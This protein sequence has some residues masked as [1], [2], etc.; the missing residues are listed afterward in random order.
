ME[1]ERKQKANE[2]IVE[3]L[4]N[5][6]IKKYCIQIEIDVCIVLFSESFLSFLMLHDSKLINIIN[7]NILGSDYTWGEEMFVWQLHPCLFDNLIKVLVRNTSVNP[8]LTSSQ[9]VYIVVA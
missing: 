5:I 8:P 6:L 1:Q 4:E 3:N 7:S 9:F 2:Y